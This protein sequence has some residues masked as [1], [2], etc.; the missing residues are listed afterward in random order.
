M[1]GDVLV[2]SILCNNLKKAFPDSE[3]HFMV[4]EGTV[5]VLDGNPN[6]DKIVIFYK[7]NQKSKRGLL[8]FAYSL[9]DENYDILIDAYSKLESWITVLLTNVPVRISYKKIGRTFLYTHNI[10]RKTKPETNYGLVIEHRLSLLEP[11]NLG[12]EIDPEPKLFVKDKEREFA[13]KL[14]REYKIDRQK[15]TLMFA[16]TGS[17]M[18]K[19]YPLK[20]MQELIDFIAG[21]FDVNILFNYNPVLKQQ[22]IRIYEKCKPETRNNIFFEVY[23]NSLRE[24]I[25]IMDACDLIIG[26]DGGAVNMAKALDKPSFTIFS[27]WIPK[28]EWGTFEDGKWHV[29]VHLKEYM[30]ELFKDK[31]KKDL[32]NET[33]DLYLQFK[34]QLFIEDLNSFLK[35]NL[36]K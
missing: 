15:P 5:P 23:G 2:S 6:I 29:S 14:F 1:I 21:S 36:Q 33:S 18:S 11:L 9:R 12:I 20:Y 35:R 26:N 32:K 27:P 16:V 8:K 10:E 17:E 7:E 13:R 3:I 34:P 19:T 31:S 24:Y 28:E 30:P 25:A 22:A 4:H